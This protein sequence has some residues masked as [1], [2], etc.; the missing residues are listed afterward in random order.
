MTVVEQM[1]NAEQ[2]AELWKALMPDLEVPPRSQFLIWAGAYSDDLV[3][4]GINRA[5]GKRRKLRD[6]TEPMTT[7]ACIRYAT[8]VMRNE[9]LGIRRFE[10]KG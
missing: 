9:L 6:T 8:S 1:A 7:D 3:S 2:F 10:P 5:A 4:R